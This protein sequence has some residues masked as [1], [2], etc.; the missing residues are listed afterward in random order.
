MMFQSKNEIDSADNH[1]VSSKEI[2][3]QMLE[4]KEKFEGELINGKY[5]EKIF[6]SVAEDFTEVNIKAEEEYELTSEKISHKWWDLL[7]KV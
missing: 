2:S 7:F 1:T 6:E 4:S 5:S 3:A